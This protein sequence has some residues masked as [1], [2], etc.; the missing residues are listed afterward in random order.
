[1]DGSREPIAPLLGP[2]LHE[3]DPQLRY[4][5]ATLLG[6]YATLP[7]VEAALARAAR[8]PNPSVRAAVVESLASQQAPTAEATAVGLLSDPVWFVRVHAARA[9]RML[10]VDLGAA[11]APLLADDSWWVRAAA[12]E[13]L[14][15]HPAAALDTLVGYL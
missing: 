13:T 15:A 3:L 10:D 1:L 2:L 11:V 5:G 12:K 6:R 9:L 7:D 14:E 4:W 8:D